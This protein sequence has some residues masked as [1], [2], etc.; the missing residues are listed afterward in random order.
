MAGTTANTGNMAKSLAV[1]DKGDV[2]VDKGVGDCRRETRTG[3]TGLLLLVFLCCF[4]SEVISFN[5]ERCIFMALKDCF[6]G[7]WTVTGM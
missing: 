6:D 1:S 5:Q 7:D 2:T 4:N 3:L